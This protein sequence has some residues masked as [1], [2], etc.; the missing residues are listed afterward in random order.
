VEIAGATRKREEVARG[1]CKRRERKI[2]DEER[3]KK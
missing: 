3:G 2:G 1:G